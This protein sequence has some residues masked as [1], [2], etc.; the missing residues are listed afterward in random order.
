MIA[1]V[2]PPDYPKPGGKGRPRWPRGAMHQDRTGCRWRLIPLDF[3]PSGT[4]RYYF[5]K[6]NDDGSAAWIYWASI[7]RML[8][9]LAPAP[10]QE[11]PY[12]R[13]TVATAI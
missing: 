2:A 7:Q 12:K 10:D 3:P 1:P 13:K 6:W 9:Y 8:R 4:V 5:D 11:R